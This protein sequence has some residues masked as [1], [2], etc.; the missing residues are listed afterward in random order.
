MAGSA[1]FAIETVVQVGANFCTGAVEPTFLGGER[2]VEFAGRFWAGKSLEV[3]EF[4]DDSF[5]GCE[6][7]EGVVDL[8]DES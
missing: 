7:F 3:T 5:F 2:N 6:D 4:E 8:V 1:G